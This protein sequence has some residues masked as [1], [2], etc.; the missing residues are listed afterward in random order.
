MIEL[1]ATP[2]TVGRAPENTV[3][4]DDDYV[5]GRHA[6]IV[7]SDP[8]RIT[9]L[10]STNGTFMDGERVTSAELYDGARI[11]IGALAMVFRFGG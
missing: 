4:L 11:G 8:P 3:V 5:S 6:E 7:L 1:G 9:D 2:I 10:G